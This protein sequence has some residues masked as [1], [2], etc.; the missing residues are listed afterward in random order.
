VNLRLEN[1]VIVKAGT[2]DEACCRDRAEKPSCQEWV[3][4]SWKNASSPVYRRWP[5]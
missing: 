5:T 1:I 4:D 3:L 2:P